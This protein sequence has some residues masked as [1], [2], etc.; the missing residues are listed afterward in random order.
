MPASARSL[1]GSVFLIQ[2]SDSD[3]APAFSGRNV[4][5]FDAAGSALAPDV[6][7]VPLSMRSFADQSAL[8]PAGGAGEKP[9][10]ASTETP[11]RLISH[12]FSFWK[13]GSA[14]RPAGGMIPP[15]PPDGVRA[16]GSPSQPHRCTGHQCGERGSASA[17]RDMHGMG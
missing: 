2:P 5:K 17:T 6:A 9:F 7:D 4:A 11:C 14:P 1:R 3:P 13:W 16:Q 12:V 10:R 8:L 15:D